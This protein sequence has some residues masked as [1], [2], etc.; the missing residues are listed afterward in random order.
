MD[1]SGIFLVIAVGANSE[2]GKIKVTRIPT[3]VTLIWWQSLI[4]GVGVAKSKATPEAA[5][6]E[7]PGDEDEPGMSQ[8]VSVGSCYLRNCH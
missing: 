5:S 2:A 1:G 4:N 8:L 3:I 6:E 7:H